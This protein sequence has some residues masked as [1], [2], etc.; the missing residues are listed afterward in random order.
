MM[1]ILKVERQNKVR[2]RIIVKMMK[3]QRLGLLDWPQVKAAL[4]GFIILSPARLLR[5]PIKSLRDGGVYGSSMLPY[6]KEVKN[7]IATTPELSEAIRAE[8]LIDVT[9]TVDGADWTGI[10]P[11]DSVAQILTMLEQH[12]RRGMVL[13]HDPF[14]RSAWRTRLLLQSLKSEGYRVVALEQPGN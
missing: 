1:L 13:L 4:N 8:G 2:I 3:L 10:T 6:L 12:N 7:I 11:E 9:V 5:D 14:S